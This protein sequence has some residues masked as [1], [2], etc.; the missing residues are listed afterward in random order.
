[1]ETTNF[2]QDCVKLS[3]NF[4]TSVNVCAEDKEKAQ[5]NQVHSSNFT[6]IL[7]NSTKPVDLEIFVKPN[8]KKKHSKK[9]NNI[10]NL[11]DDNFDNNNNNDNLGIELKKFNILEAMSQRD[12]FHKSSHFLIIG[13][14]ASGKTHLVKEI[15]L[16]LKNNNIIENIIFFSNPS[17]ANEYISILKPNQFNKIKNNLESDDIE[18]ILEFQS[19]NLTKPLLLVFD[20]VIYN[21][22]FLHKN[23]YF[24]EL[25]CNARNYNIYTIFT[26]QYPLGLYPEIRVNFDF[27]FI[28]QDNF[29]STRKRIYDYYFGIIPQFK[30]FDKIMSEYCENYGIM[31]LDNFHNDNNSFEENVMHYRCNPIVLEN[32]QLLE[33]LKLNYD[34]NNY[35]KK[36]KKNKIDK[37]YKKEKK[38]KSMFVSSKIE[39]ISDMK[40]IE[41]IN[42]IDNNI[43]TNNNKVNDDVYFSDNS[44]ILKSNFI[45]KNEVIAKIKK[46]NKLIKKITKQNEKLYELL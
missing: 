30:L 7:E 5:H 26:M 36:D 3:E 44:D 31:V 1:M 28:F 38:N 14:R 4:E 37:K 8:K 25:M 19:H 43:S 20:D 17:S 35:H 34:E 23:K 2:D 12:N 22:S 27:I 6:H 13:K 16:L 11:D 24:F 32:N 41:D 15:S 21:N 18:K 40:L 42:Q 39:D 46:N 45:D 10:N 29:I 9:K 33:L